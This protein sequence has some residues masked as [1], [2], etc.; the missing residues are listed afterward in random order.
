MIAGTRYPGEFEERLKTVIDEV[1]GACEELVV[2]I[3]ELYTVVA[4]G[5]GEGATSFTASRTATRPSTACGLRRRRASTR[6][7]GSLRWSG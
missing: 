6:R 2:F 5:A 7:T 3:D 1:R 4:A